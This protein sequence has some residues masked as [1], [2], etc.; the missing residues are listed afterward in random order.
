MSAALTVTLPWP[1]TTNNAYATRT[2]RTR[3]GKTTARKVKTNTA[4]QYAANIEW[5]L[6]GEPTAR[7][8]RRALPPDAHFHVT[9]TAHAGSKRR[10]DLANLE[11]LATDAVFAF[12]CFDDSRIDRLTL[13]RGELHRDDPS[14][15]YTVEVAA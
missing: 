8:F 2:M 1:P 6:T 5:Q 10:H 4:R 15:T 13:I 14:L 12:L 11:K 7:V 9:I 3:D